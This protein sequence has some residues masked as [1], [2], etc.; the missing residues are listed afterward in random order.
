MPLCCSDGALASFHDAAYY[1]SWACVW[2][3]MRAWLPP[4]R[5]LSLARPGLGAHIEAVQD[6]YDRLARAHVAVGL[7]PSFHLLPDDAHFPQIRSRL[8]DGRLSPA[9]VPLGHPETQ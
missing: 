9:T 3:Y 4:L 6:A 5:G 8:L 2:H 1:G 7:S